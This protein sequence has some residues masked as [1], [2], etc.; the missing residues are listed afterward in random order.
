MEKLSPIAGEMR[1]L[2][3]EPKHIDGILGEGAARAEAIATPILNDV[4]DIVGF[5]RS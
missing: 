5:V 3:A 1:R 4:K 2:L